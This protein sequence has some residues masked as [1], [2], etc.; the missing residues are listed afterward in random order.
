MLRGTVKLCSCD[1][2]VR[3]EVQ[4]VL[5][6]LRTGCNSLSKYTEAGVELEEMMGL[7]G[8]GN[9]VVLCTLGSV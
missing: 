2:K 6:S 1:I 3:E 4:T 8:I 7:P 9:C 5:G